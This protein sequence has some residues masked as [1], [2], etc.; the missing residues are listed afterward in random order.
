MN[1]FSLEFLETDIYYNISRLFISRYGYESGGEN[2]QTSS[3]ERSRLDWTR[4]YNT[5]GINSDIRALPTKSTLI[6]I[7]VSQQPGNILISH[8]SNESIWTHL[9]PTKNPLILLDGFLANWSRIWGFSVTNFAN[10]CLKTGKN[11]K[12]TF[13]NFHQKRFSYKMT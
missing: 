1:E 10:F 6:Q 13:I 8:F 4:I 7:G 2:S 5:G 3:G 11:E 9:L 12:R